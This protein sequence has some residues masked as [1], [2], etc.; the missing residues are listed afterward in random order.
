MN[1]R[2]RLFVALTTILFPFHSANAEVVNVSC[3]SEDVINAGWNGPLTISYSG[4]PEGEMSVKSAHI[5]LILPASQT[6]RSGEVDGAEVRAVSIV[7]SGETMST[8]PDSSALLACASQTIQ[9]EFKDD[10]DMQ[11]MAL[12]GCIPQTELGPV[13]VK[14]QAT[15][16]V[17]LLP[18]D[19]G[20]IVEI[21]RR[22]IDA[23]MPAGGEVSIETFPKDCKLSIQ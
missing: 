12:M 4:G 6:E 2:I 17:G 18:G 19:E 5:D 8:M 15:V 9:P 10:A 23:L 7:G 22:Y 20:V 16:R 13:D 21:K 11:A 3:V 1:L 14:I